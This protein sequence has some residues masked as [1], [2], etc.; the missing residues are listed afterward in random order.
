MI[1]CAD[2][3]M[4]AHGLTILPAGGWRVGF[5]DPTVAGWTIAVCYL[6]TA[7]ACVWALRV[8][9]I[10]A[11]LSREWRGT[12]RRG[13][14]RTRAYQA[15]LLFWGLLGLLFLFLGVN[16]QIDLQTWLTE[17]GRE[18]AQ[19]QGWY[20]QRGQVQTLFVVCIV[21]GGL[22]SLA[23]LLRL[24][25]DL[26]PRHIPAFAG[27]ILLACFV[28]ARALSFHQLNDV[29]DWDGLGLKLRWMMEL[30]GIAVVG[31]CAAMNCWWYK[32]GPFVE[33]PIA[34]TP[35]VEGVVADRGSKAG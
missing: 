26:L 15:S 21:G 27:M 20:D 2:I 1:A 32:L 22:L 8:A 4:T 3:G 10:G 29:L 12:E 18:A 7:A 17:M 23:V 19:A 16:K 28:G 24:T 5:G 35:A 34:A 13:R 11:R 25:R 30:T 9:W 14:D 6:L 31:L 33:K